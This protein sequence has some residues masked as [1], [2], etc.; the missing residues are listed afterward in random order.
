MLIHI[1]NI[2]YFL[3]VS[4]ILLFKKLS[5]SSEEERNERKYEKVYRIDYN[6]QYLVLHCDINHSENVPYS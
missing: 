2:K 6:S 3:S 4:V 1:F 5:L